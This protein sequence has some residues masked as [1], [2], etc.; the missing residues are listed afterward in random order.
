M[1]RSGCSFKQT[2]VGEESLRD[3]LRASAQEARVSF[4]EGVGGDV[5]CNQA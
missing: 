1:N 5:A 2:F 3:E 4:K